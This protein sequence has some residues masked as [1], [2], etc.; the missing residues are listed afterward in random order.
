MAVDQHFPGSVHTKKSSNPAQIEHEFGLADNDDAN[1]F[2]LNFSF[3]DSKHP[4]YESEFE[5]VSLE[6]FQSLYT[7]V[8]EKQLALL[9]RIEISVLVCV[10]GKPLIEWD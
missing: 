9:R 3:V 8:C 4:R 1:R 6:N 2:Y 10:K 7:I 5:Q